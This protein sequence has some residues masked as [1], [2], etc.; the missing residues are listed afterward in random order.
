MAARPL[1]RQTM[2]DRQIVVMEQM[3]LHLVWTGSRIFVKPLPR[4]LLNKDFWENH[5]CRERELYRRAK[6]MLLSYAWLVCREIDLRMATSEELGLLPK[7]LTWADWTAFLEDFLKDMDLGNPQDVNQ[8]YQYG[9]L[10]EDRLNWIYR[11]AAQHPIR[12]YYY[13]YHQYSVFF[14][15]NFAW[16]IVIFA[17]VTIV[18]TA[19]QLG[20]VTDHLAKDDRFQNISFGFAVFSIVV[21]AIAVGVI[22]ILFVVLCGNNLVATF[23]VWRGRARERRNNLHP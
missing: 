10:R 2:M 14:R 4:Y 11:I 17:Y 22:A 5:L 18:L 20:L 9:E 15:H 19:M 3:D 12:G 6:G 16:L 1:H 23:L 8:R 21:P 7:S 13:S